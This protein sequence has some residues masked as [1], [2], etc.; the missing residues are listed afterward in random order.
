MRIWMILKWEMRAD[1]KAQ[2]VPAR[3][4]VDAQ[5]QGARLQGRPVT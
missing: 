1:A 4:V 3:L 2:H 5:G